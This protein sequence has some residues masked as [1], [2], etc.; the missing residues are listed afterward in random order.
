M[1]E[2]SASMPDFKLDHTM[3]HVKDLEKS[4]DFYYR[5]PVMNLLRPNESPVGQFANTFIGYTDEDEGTNL[6]LTYKLESG[7]GLRK[8]KRLGALS[9]CLRNQR[10]PQTAWR[11]VHQGTLAD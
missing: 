8:G 3:L 9:D 1:T 5:I 6:E 4:L 2:I 11:R 10:I 7:E